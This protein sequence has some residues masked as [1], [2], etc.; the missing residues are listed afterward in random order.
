MKLTTFVSLYTIATC[1]KVLLIPSYHSTDLDVHRHWKATVRELPLSRWYYD[2]TS[3]RHT[4]DYPPGFMWFESVLAKNSVTEWTIQNLDPQCLALRPDPQDRDKL[5]ISDSCL[6]FLRGTVIASD[7]L[8]WL[9][10]YF[11]SHSLDNQLSFSLPLFVTLTFPPSLF[12][13][14]HVHF[15][16]NG[17]MIGVWLLSLGCL[18]RA[19][20]NTS[21]KNKEN[22]MFYLLAGAFFFA[23]LLTM[24]H[25][26]LFVAPWYGVYLLRRVCFSKKNSTLEFQPAAFFKLAFVTATTLLLP[27]LPFLYYDQTSPSTFLQQLFSRLFPFQ[28]GLVHDYWAGN[29]WALYSAAGKVVASLPDDVPPVFTLVLI[30]AGQSFGLYA[31]WVAAAKK[32]LTT[33]LI[34]LAYTAAVAFSF[35]YHVHEKAVLNVLIPL[36]IVAYLPK[37]DEDQSS[38]YAAN[39]FGIFYHATAWGTLGLMPLLYEPREFLLKAASFLLLISIL[40]WKRPQNQQT[41]SWFAYLYQ[42]LHVA[43]WFCTWILV[44][45]LPLSLFGKYT[46][47]PLAGTS[48]LVACGLLVTW[49][50]LAWVML[51]EVQRTGSEKNKV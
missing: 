44:D 28:R 32:S 2:T 45:V 23:A 31:A 48:V 16:Y 40:S 29:I 1:I 36:T 34:S 25:L 26:Y 22:S 10:A 38:D 24:K 6:F 33:A 4:A 27:C 50:R 35:G 7:A 51:L 11:V 42:S 46:F 15:Q 21:K 37:Q 49:A 43:G 30:L 18:L 39:I 20:S 12:W 17:C 9:G 41:T 5:E 47:V 14:D 8:L 3:Q 13:L 19:N